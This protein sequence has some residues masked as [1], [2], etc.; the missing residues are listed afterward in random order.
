MYAKEP[1]GITT[2]GKNVY[3]ALDGWIARPHWLERGCRE[4][5]AKGVKN[6]E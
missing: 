4:V 1:G 2:D 6:S 5:D 3:E